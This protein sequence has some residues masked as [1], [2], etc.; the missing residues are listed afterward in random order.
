[1][2][3]VLSEEV[4]RAKTYM[5]GLFQLGLQT[6]RSQVHSFARYELTGPGARW[7]DQFCARIRKVTPLEVQR[8]AKKYL[9]TDQKT[10]VLLTPGVKGDENVRLV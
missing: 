7:V 2:G 9:E 10:W 6:N 3:N 5:T 1:M 4:Q 8:A